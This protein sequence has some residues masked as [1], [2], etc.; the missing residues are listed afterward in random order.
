VQAALAL[1]TSAHAA[2]RGTL[3]ADERFIVQPVLRS[4][5]LT[6]VSRLP[7]RHGAWLGVAITGVTM[8][9][10]GVAGAKSRTF[11][12]PVTVINSERVCRRPGRER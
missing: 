10:C 6:D 7:H 5:C 12:G 9:A 8:T 4:C 3:H 1:I 2:V 11:V